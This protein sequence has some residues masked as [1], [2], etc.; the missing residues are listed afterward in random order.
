MHL[1]YTPSE[2]EHHRHEATVSEKHC[3]IYKAAAL[4]RN[5]VL[6]KV[7]LVLLTAMDALSR[8]N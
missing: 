6:K 3:A 1:T 2:A 7:Q 8:L 5:K 4:Y